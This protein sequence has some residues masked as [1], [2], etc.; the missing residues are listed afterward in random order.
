M[1]IE[2][3]KEHL[4]PSS[5]FA[6]LIVLSVGVA[7]LMIRPSSRWPR[8][9]FLAV[10]VTYWLI[11][12]RSGAMLLVAGLGH[13]FTALHSREEARGAEA[14][15]VLGGGA[16][17]YS[18]GGQV[19][20][21]L[22][23]PSILRALEGARVAKLIDARLVVASGGEP[24][25]DVQLKPES[26]M[27]SAV[28][29]AAGV[30][31]DRVIEESSSKTTRDQARL[32]PEILR[33]RGIARFVLVTSPVHMGRSLALFRAQ[34]IEPVPSVS[35]LRSEHLPPPSLIVPD[36]GSLLISDEALYDYLAWIYYWWKGWLSP[37]KT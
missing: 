26:E 5:P 13:G 36:G 8:R 17:T 35:P 9:Y 24:R 25:P 10:L 11:S 4:H 6:M 2:Y 28:L 30:P 31:A 27:L 23:T 20:G 33:D 34:G 29:V 12:T 15:V 1:I 32:I 21:L 16:A 3:L 14:V 7:W 22:T 18:G 19:V 37:A